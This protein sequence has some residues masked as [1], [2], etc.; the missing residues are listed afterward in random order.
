MDRRHDEAGDSKQQGKQPKERG[1][2]KA[3][4]FSYK[5][6]LPLFCCNQVRFLDIEVKGAV[7][8]WAALKEQH[9]SGVAANCC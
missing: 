1:R 4:L 8:E 2:N 7:C 5:C 9:I 6:M 3:F